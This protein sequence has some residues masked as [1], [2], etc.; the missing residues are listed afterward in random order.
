MQVLKD[1]GLSADDVKL[2]NLTPDAAA[3]AYQVGRTD[4]AVTY[5]PFLQKANAA[6]KDGRIIFDSSKM[7]T[8]IIDVYLFST[9]FIE[10]NPDAIKGFVQGIFK[11]MD[12]MNTNRQEA[13]TI[14]GKRLQLTP[15][16]VEEQLK[17]VRLIDLPTNLKMLSDPQSDIY[18]LKQM[19]TIGEFLLKQKQ[20]PQMPDISKILEPRFLKEA[21]A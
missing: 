18:L 1:A 7:P 21:E 2:T 8:A 10:A 11:A 4:I 13:L 9:K 5:S 6:Q 16:E 17:G 3:T 19:K 15:D 14:A 20:I 12:F